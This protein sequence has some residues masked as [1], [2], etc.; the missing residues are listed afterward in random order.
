MD[1]VLALQQAADRGLADSHG[2]QNQ[3]PVR[4]RFVAWNPDMALEGATLAGGQR[5]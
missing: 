2:A 5:R 4:D 3:R 1:N